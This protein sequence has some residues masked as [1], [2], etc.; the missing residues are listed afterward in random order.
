MTGKPIL[1][2]E[3]QDAFG[4]A[5][6][7]MLRSLKAQFS[8][9]YAFLRESAQNSLDARAERF[10]VILRQIAPGRIEIEVRDDGCG[11]DRKAVAAFKTMFDSPKEG[12]ADALGQ[13]GIGRLS[14]FALPGMF[15]VE[16]LTVREMGTEGYRLTFDGEGY[17][18]GEQPVVLVAAEVRSELGSSSGTRIRAACAVSDPRTFVEGAL[19][20]VRRELRWVAMPVFVSAVPMAGRDDFAAVQ[21]ESVSSEEARIAGPL[22][23]AYRYKLPVTEEAG[24]VDLGVTPDTVGRYTPDPKCDG[25]V[26]TAGGLVL[27]RGSHL[28]WL[29][30]DRQFNV[31]NLVVAVESKAGWSFPI[32]RNRVYRDIRFRRVVPRVFRSIISGH[33]VRHLIADLVRPAR[34]RLCLGYALHVR[35]LLLD[36]LDMAQS[37]GFAADLPDEIGHAP[38]FSVHGAWDRVVSLDDLKAQ[39]RVYWS[40]RKPELTLLRYGATADD[41]AA[42]VPVVVDL[43]T[44]PW[45]AKKVLDAFFPG[46][47][48]EIRGDNLVLADETT[49]RELAPAGAELRRLLPAARFR[50]TLAAVTNGRLK[51]SRVEAARLGRLDGSSDPTTRAAAVGDGEVVHFNLSCA[52]VRAMLDLGQHGTNRTFVGAFLL[53]ELLLAKNL[54]VPER[55]RSELLRRA[56]RWAEADS[57]DGGRRLPIFRLGDAENFETFLDRLGETAQV[58]AEDIIL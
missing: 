7:D 24:V 52:P 29:S 58:E 3:S 56:C 35:Q 18:E 5:P 15:E 30:A 45:P 51:T 23:R 50:M 19:A 17:A 9:C 54:S 6:E 46:R 34:D 49:D 31:Y 16:V 1:S 11:M 55:I 25:Y 47:L 44:T 42:G 37:Y 41:A 20:Y 28:D 38:L 57:G 10:H 27:E 8:E 22:S 43:W 53:R 4:V 39:N 14:A 26:L 36:L 40:G 21:D 32:G 12:E 13:F 2:M 48:Q 33:Y